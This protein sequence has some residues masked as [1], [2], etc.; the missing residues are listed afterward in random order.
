M[1]RRLKVYLAQLT[2]IAVRHATCGSGICFYW[3]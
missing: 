3:D 1:L 2:V